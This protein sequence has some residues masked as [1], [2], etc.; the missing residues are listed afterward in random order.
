MNG[1]AQFPSWL[2]FVIVIGVALAIG[3]VA[4][5]IYLYMRPKLKRDDRPTD[6]QIAQEEMNRILQPIEDEELAKEIEQYKD[7]KE[8]EQVI[9]A[10]VKELSQQLSVFKRPA[11][12][13]V[14]KETLPRTATSKIKRR[15]VKTMIEK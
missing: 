1:S 9:K 11:K 12:I 14:L 13:I 4:L 5:L 2:V 7:E 15:D 8:L 10:E 6:E 3:L